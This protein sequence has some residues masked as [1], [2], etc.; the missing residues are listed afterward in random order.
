MPERSS[1]MLAWRTLVFSGILVGMGILAMALPGC[2][3]EGGTVGPS[4]GDVKVAPVVN[5]APGVVPI[6]QEKPEHNKAK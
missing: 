6:D 4:G 2:G 1:I 5:P 3:G